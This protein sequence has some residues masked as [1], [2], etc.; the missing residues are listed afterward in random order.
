LDDFN[1]SVNLTQPLYAGGKL[2]S[3]KESA[4]LEKQKT[5]DGL[6]RTMADLA[7]DV[8]SAYYSACHAEAVLSAKQQSYRL[9]SISER[10][11]DKRF[12]S[13]WDRLQ[14][15]YGIQSGKRAL[16]PAGR[17]SANFH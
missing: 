6:A 13:G 4:E 9:L 10:Y 14:G 1:L 3:E 17:T 16:G 5:A 8:T 7:I 12:L 15:F 11:T 2:W